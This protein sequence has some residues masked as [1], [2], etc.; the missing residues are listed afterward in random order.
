MHRP[1]P[2]RKISSGFWP[3]SRSVPDARLLGKGMAWCRRN[4]VV[5]GLIVSVAALLI[6]VAGVSTLDSVPLGQQLTKTIRAETAERLA[7]QDAQLK[8]WD[9]YLA[10]ASARGSSRQVGQRFAALAAIENARHLLPESATAPTKKCGCVTPRFP[11]WPYL[12]FASSAF[13]ESCRKMSGILIR[14]MDTPG[15]YS[16]TPA[17]R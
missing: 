13:P 11:A 14:R 12:I 4:P 15:S 7:R 10:E 9:S 16:S 8:L 6:A 2:W 1:A 5:A 3:I 17:V